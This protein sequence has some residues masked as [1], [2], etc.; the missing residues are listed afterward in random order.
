M[1]YGGPN[2]CVFWDVVD[3]PFPDGQSPFYIYQA[4][5]HLQIEGDLSIRAFVDEENVT[6]PLVKAYEEAGITFIAVPKDKNERVNC[7]IPEILLWTVEHPW[8]LEL[9]VISKNIEKESLFLDVLDDV[10]NLNCNVMIAV[11]PDLPSSQLHFV[12]FKCF[13]KSL[14]ETS[15]ISQGHDLRRKRS[16]EGTSEGP[17]SEEGTSQGN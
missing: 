7:M 3:F 13:L 9:F 6:D 4:L 15:A 8:R 11:P 16:E 2:P 1:F 17:K 10:V 12:S 14:L 5:K